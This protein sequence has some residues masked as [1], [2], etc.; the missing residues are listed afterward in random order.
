MIGFFALYCACLSS[1][2]GREVWYNLESEES[3]RLFQT[4]HHELVLR[5]EASKPAQYHGYPFAHAAEF[6]KDRLHVNLRAAY[7]AIFLVGYLAVLLASWYWFARMRY[8]AP[9]I[10]IGLSAIAAYAGP[11][12][13]SVAVYHPSD[14]YGAALYALALGA[15]TD[16]RIGSLLLISLAAGFVWQKHVTI[17]PV[18]FLHFGMRRQWRLAL[19]LG[20][21]A[22]LLAWVGPSYYTA[23]LGVHPMIAGGILSPAA[24]LRSMPK[25]IAYQLAFGGPPLVAL[26]LCWKDVHPAVRAAM[27]TYPTIL[28]LYAAQRLFWFEMRSFWITVPVFGAVLASIASLVSME[29]NPHSRSGSVSQAP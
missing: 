10:M 2:L 16:R 17:A 14:L 1:N 21:A 19:V 18:L 13:W 7:T 25:S 5:N 22:P 11:L 29:P 8:D 4:Q 24:W 26:A 12:M 20:I 23:K 27:V 9:A 6:L 28:L 15:M 3:M